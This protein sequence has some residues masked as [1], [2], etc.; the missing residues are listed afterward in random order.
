MS[1]NIQTDR[2]ESTEESTRIAGLF[3]SKR[4]TAVAAAAVAGS[5]LVAVPLIGATPFSGGTIDAKPVASEHQIAFK[6]DPR[7]IG[8]DMLPTPP[9]PAP[10]AT[11][12]PTSSPERA[13]RD[14]SRTA[15][16]SSS[17]SSTTS[18]SPKSI[19]QAQLAERGW[20]GQFSC[21]DSLWTK[22]SGWKVSASN[23]SGAYGIPQALPGSKMASSGSDWQSNP[24][25]QIDWGLDYISETYGTP[26]A[27]WS[28]SKSNN[29]Y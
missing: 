10:T 17:S 2:L 1:D 24:A 12:A 15:L 18:G 9:K 13:S 5:V 21:L 25:T 29:W 4:R 19:A 26:C 20:S 16:P 28:H 7:G 3:R 8:T 27:A 14:A 22:E 11:K 23:P 6:P